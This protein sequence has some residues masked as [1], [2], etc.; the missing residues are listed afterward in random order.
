MTF[1][2]LW[3]IVL[4][5]LSAWQM[6]SNGGGIQGF[7]IQYKKYNFFLILISYIFTIYVYKKSAVNKLGNSTTTVDWD[8][9]VCNS[10]P[11]FYVRPFAFSI[12][13]GSSS[14]YWYNYHS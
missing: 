11:F 12:D 7:Y 3:A 10:A 4:I 6:Q 14:S 5:G 2:L 8:A 9:G 13:G 1:G